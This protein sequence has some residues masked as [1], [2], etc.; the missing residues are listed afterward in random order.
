MILAELKEVMINY[1]IKDTD[2]V[3]FNLSKDADNISVQVDPLKPNEA[4]IVGWKGNHSSAFA[5]DEGDFKQRVANLKHH[6][7]SL[8][9]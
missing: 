7:M 1:G 8:F 3:S 2:I 4:I 5:T 9:G 6:Q